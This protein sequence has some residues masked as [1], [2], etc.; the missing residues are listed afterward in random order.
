MF[1][2]QF[3]HQLDA[4]GRVAVPAQFRRGLGE[5]S[6]I[7][8]GPERR[9]VI[10]P[11]AEW[12]E[13]A[14]SHRLTAATPAEARSYMRRL[15]ANAREVELDA[16]GRILLTPEQRSFAGI[17]DRAVF[18]GTGSLV[19]VVGE[20]LWDQETAQLSPDDFT[21]LHDAVHRADHAPQETA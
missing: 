2:G 10:Y 13:M 17:D 21:A 15:F 5:G 12:Q 19:E 7:V 1:L 20:A 4:K 6:V 14:Q 8:F 18:V 16:Q 11:H 9:L 3:R